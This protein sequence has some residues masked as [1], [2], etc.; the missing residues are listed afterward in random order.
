MN[1]F[2]LKCYTYTLSFFVKNLYNLNVVFICRMTKKSWFGAL[3]GNER[4][5]HHFIMAQN[6]PLSQVKADLVHALLS[7]CV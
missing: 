4:E 3:M 6:K 7:V 1:M 5:E 2:A